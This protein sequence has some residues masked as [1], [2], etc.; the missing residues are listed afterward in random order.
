MNPS[1][2]T[3]FTEHHCPDWACP[4]CGAISLAIQPGTFH[5]SA[6]PESLNIWASSEGETED[7]RLVFSCLLRCE[8]SRCKAVVAASGSGYVCETPGEA[9]E[10]GEEPFYEL[11][12]ARS[13]TPALVAFVIPPQCPTSVAQSLMQSFALFLSA[14]G[15]AANVIRIALE[16][17]MDALGVPKQRSLH[18]R[19]ESLP[20]QYKEHQDALMAI[21]FLGNAGSHEIDKVTAPDIDHAY[22]IIEFVLRKIY[23]GSTASVRQLTA[24]L[25]TRFRPASRST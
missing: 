2:L 17:L 11:F 24:R 14:P 12:Q 8:R 22:T 21:K 10:Q 13:F 9:C 18:Q 1:L 19:I 15:A 5:Y 23:E 7:I 6:Q 20:T 16:Q 4:S 25:E 3:Y